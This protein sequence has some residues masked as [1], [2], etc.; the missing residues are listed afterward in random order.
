MLTFWTMAICIYGVVVAALFSAVGRLRESTLASIIYVTGFLGLNV[1]LSRVSDPGPGILLAAAAAFIGLIFNVV[2]MR[3]A[4]ARLLTALGRA[5][6][7]DD[8]LR[9]AKSYDRAEA[10]E[11]RGDYEAAA[12]LYREAIAADARDAE[13]HRRLA[14]ALL[15]DGKPHDA[16]RVLKQLVDLCTD[17]E[18]RCG[19]IFRLAEVLHEKLNDERAAGELYEL[20]SRDYANTR[21]DEYARGRLE[22]LK[23]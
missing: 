9:Y 19:A 5:L 21:F 7:G 23:R 11:S 20:V 15:K 2:A 14:D 17:P 6:T 16:G 1:Q 22:A 3:F 12:G 13:A 10:A 8:A 4:L 18:D